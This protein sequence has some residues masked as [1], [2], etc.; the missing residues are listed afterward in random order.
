M[1][2][3]FLQRWLLDLNPQTGPSKSCPTAFAMESGPELN[4]CQFYLFIYTLILPRY[5]YLL[6]VNPTTLGGRSTATRWL[7]LASL[8][9][10]KSTAELSQTGMLTETAKEYFSVQ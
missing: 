8:E 2:S 9:S 5:R 1:L 7:W 10:A 3:E 6:E 4:T